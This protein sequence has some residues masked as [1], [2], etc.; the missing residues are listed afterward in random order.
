MDIQDV[1]EIFDREQ[2][3]EVMLP[4]MRR[5]E[6]ANVIRMIPDKKNE[7]MII[8]SHLPNKKIEDV[9]LSEIG[10]FSKLGMDFEWK[11]YRH[12]QPE[13]LNA[14]LANMGFEVET[15]DSVMVYDLAE[16]PAWVHEDISPGIRR[17][18]S[19]EEVERVLTVQRKV[20]DE[21]LPNLVSYLRLQ[22]N[23]YPDL[24]SI[25]AAYDNKTPVSSA[26]TTYYPGSQFA[27]L[28]G[29][30]TLPDF[31]KQGYY[32]SL[33]KIRM[34]EAMQRG[35]RYL[36]VDASPMSRPILENF[37]FQCITHAWRCVWR[38]NQN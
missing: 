16:A 17:I 27:G 2:R 4:G 1:L 8:Y 12:D 24:I 32:S 22:L 34:Q 7:G 3:K 29:G 6:T 37:G 35:V 38:V 23:Q 18:T 19:S 31:R 11:A 13:G 15:P 26:W 30:S 28:W 9:I 21:E 20:W 25:F 36:T 5:E 14:L 10:Y 33:L